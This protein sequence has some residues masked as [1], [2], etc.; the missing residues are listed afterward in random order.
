V[1]TPVCIIGPF[2]VP[3]VLTKSLNDGA[4]VFVTSMVVLPIVPII[5]LFLVFGSISNSGA[6]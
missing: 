2:V 4:L 3:S 1:I 5:P 6:A